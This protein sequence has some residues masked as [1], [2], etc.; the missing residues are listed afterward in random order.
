MS[1]VALLVITGFGLGAMYFLIASGLSLIANNSSSD[2][3]TLKE[4]PISGSPGG[5]NPIPLPSAAWAGLT[6]MLGLGL[7]SAGKKA[8]HKLF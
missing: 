8:Y 4:M 3:F 2:H 1:T 7:F 5:P 6:T